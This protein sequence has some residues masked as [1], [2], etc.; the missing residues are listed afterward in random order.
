[1]L[2]GERVGAVD[3]GTEWSD[4]QVSAL[5]AGFR[6]GLNEVSLVPAWTLRGETGLLVKPISAGQPLA[7]RLTSFQVSSCP[8]S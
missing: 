7:F 6:R 3:F 4:S 2:N 1:M 5:S 8:T